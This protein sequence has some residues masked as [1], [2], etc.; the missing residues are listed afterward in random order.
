MSSPEL[1]AFRE[2]A[3]GILKNSDSV[4][5]SEFSGAGRIPEKE[6]L[7]SGSCRPRESIP[8]PKQVGRTGYGARM[9][10]GCTGL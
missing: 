8:A 5:Q 1:P 6:A 9:L 7:R 10:S 3:S 4:A 2:R